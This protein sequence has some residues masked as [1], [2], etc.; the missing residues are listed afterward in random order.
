VLRD[1]AY[2]AVAVDDIDCLEHN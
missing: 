2:A 1:V